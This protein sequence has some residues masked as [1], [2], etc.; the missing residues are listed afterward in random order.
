VLVTFNESD[1]AAALA[2]ADPATGEFTRL[3][4]MPPGWAVR[5]FAPAPGGTAVLFAA[6]AH[7][8]SYSGVCLLTLATGEQ[9]WFADT[10][11]TVAYAALSPDGRT[12]ATLGGALRLIDVATAAER[13]LWTGPGGEGG[14]SWSPDGAQLAAG[15]ETAV[16]VLDAATGEVLGRHPEMEILPCPN[17]AWLAPASW[18]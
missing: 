7:D 14:L 17:G 2:L 11:Q 13:T 3:P 9:R 5:S 4:P 15:D 12:I 16:V 8:G 18:C 1:P 6:H 10:D